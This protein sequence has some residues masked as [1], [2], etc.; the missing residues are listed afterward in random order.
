MRTYVIFHNVIFCLG[1]VCVRESCVGIHSNDCNIT[2]SAYG[3]TP[4]KIW[5]IMKT[6]CVYQ[7]QCDT[8][9][10]YNIRI[11]SAKIIQSLKY[12]HELHRFWNMV[13]SSNEKLPYVNKKHTYIWSNVRLLICACWSFA[14]ENTNNVNIVYSYV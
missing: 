5:L 12:M 8:Y 11:N 13:R 3:W 1:I 14:N 6:M 2:I 9:P 10:L 4:E 7:V